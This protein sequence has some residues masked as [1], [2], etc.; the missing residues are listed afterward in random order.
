MDHII[1]ER[2]DKKYIDSIAEFQIK[3][4]METEQMQ[5]DRDTVQKG[6]RRMFDEPERGFYM[7]ARNDLDELVGSLLILKEWSDWRN[8][9]VWWIHSVYIVPGMRGKGIFTNLYERIK[10]MA[11]QEK[12]KGLRL[13]VDKQNFHAQKIYHKLGMTNQHY[14]MFEMMLL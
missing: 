9:D 6:V 12:V 3:M 7:V 11:S 8:A 1:I 4:A 14:E 2:A 10:E 13:Y 5:L